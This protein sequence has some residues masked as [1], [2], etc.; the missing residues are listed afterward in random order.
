VIDFTCCP[1]IFNGRAGFAVFH[2]S[3]VSCVPQKSASSASVRNSGI[4]LAFFKRICAS[5]LVYFLRKTRLSLSVMSR[6]VILDL[7]WNIVVAGD[8]LTLE[9]SQSNSNQLAPLT[10][11]DI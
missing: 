10:L 9:S 6:A 2:N 3:L 4:D 7:F 1:G 5:L 11:P 8:V